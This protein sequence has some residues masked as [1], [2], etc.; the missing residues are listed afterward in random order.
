MGFPL[1]KFFRKARIEMAA[2]KEVNTVYPMIM[3]KRVCCK[4]KPSSK[5]KVGVLSRNQ[6]AATIQIIRTSAIVPIQ[7]FNP[8]FLSSFF[9]V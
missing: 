6:I 8:N 7:A 1:N 4:A 3:V 5:I 2:C 9:K